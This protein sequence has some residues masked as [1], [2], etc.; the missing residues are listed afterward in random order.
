M[1]PIKLTNEDLKNSQNLEDLQRQTVPGVSTLF[2]S[3]LTEVHRQGFT[4]KRVK[5]P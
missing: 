3:L 4:E 1:Q 2:I 5:I